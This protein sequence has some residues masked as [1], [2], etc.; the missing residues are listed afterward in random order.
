V[1]LGWY[2]GGLVSVLNPGPV[3]TSYLYI[4]NSNSVRFAAPGSAVRSLINLSGNSNLTLQQPGSQVTGMTFHGSSSDALSINDTSVLNLS[5]G[6]GSGPGWIFRWQDPSVGTWETT[7]QTQIAA[8]RIA[9]ASSSGYSVF[10]EGGYTYVATPSTIFWNGGGADNSWSTA[11]NW[12]GTA[13]TAGHFLRF[14]SLAVGGH[15]SNFNNLAPN[16]LFDG[17]FFDG[18]A[19]GYNLQGNAIQLSGFV[20]NQS[21]SNQ[22]ISLNIQLVPGSG[23]FDGATFETDSM[24]ITDSGAI[25]GAGMMLVKTGSGT[26]VLS[27]GAPGNTYSG[28]TEVLAGKLIA[29]SPDAILDGSDLIVGANAA[30]LFSAPVVAAP[31][32]SI[33]ASPAPVPETGTLTLFLAALGAAA[34]HRQIFRGSAV[35]MRR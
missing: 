3:N 30:A 11:A 31:S 10:D 14:G 1:F 19:P 4:G 16:T 21:G 34:V 22:I 20:V 29:A 5:A 23:A 2:S 33:A 12:N 17:I 8:G 6:S 32:A 24:K 15:T 26:L 9:V 35:T 25:S 27:P 13:P 28:G 7:L 18:A